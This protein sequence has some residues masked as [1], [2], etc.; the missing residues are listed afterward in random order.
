[1]NPAATAQY[2]HYNQTANSLDQYGAA[3]NHYQ[4]ASINQSMLIRNLNYSIL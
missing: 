4:F 1:M 3:A 2:N